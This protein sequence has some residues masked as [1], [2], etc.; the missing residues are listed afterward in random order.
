MFRTL[1]MFLS[2][3]TDITVCVFLPT[4]SQAEDTFATVN[5]QR[6]MYLGTWLGDWS[7]D[8]FSRLIYCKDMNSGVMFNKIEQAQYVQN[9]I[10]LAYFYVHCLADEVELATKNPRLRNNLYFDYIKNYEYFVRRPIK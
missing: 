7:E 4:K 2:S 10:A 6:G 5:H 8:P 3:H 9:N 1:S